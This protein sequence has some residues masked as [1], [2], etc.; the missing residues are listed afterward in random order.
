MQQLDPALL[1]DEE[2]AH[3][4]D[5]HQRHLIEIQSQKRLGGFDLRLELREILRF[6]PTDQPEDRASIG[7][8][9]LDAPG[10]LKAYAPSPTDTAL[11]VVGQRS[12]PN[13]APPATETALVNPNATIPA[14][15]ARNTRERSPVERSATKPPAA[16]IARRTRLP[17]SGHASRPPPCEAKYKE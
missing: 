4:P 11:F 5:V 12:R 13:Q 3:Y 1:A 9:S 16:A 6:D 7:G 17:T 8:N 2:K 10:H 14:L 15:C